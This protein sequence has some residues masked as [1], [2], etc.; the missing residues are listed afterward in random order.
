MLEIFFKYYPMLAM[1]GTMDLT[2]SET[3]SGRK[4]TFPGTEEERTEAKLPSRS[5]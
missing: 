5:S 4:V 3:G 1:L 2:D